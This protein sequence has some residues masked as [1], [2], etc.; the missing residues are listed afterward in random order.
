[1][2]EEHVKMILRRELVFRYLGHLCAKEASQEQFNL[3][4]LQVLFLDF[5]KEND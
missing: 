2:A 1:M 5:S 3:F 4:L